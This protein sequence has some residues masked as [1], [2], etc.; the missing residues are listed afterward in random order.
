MPSQERGLDLAAT[1]DAM[2]D[3]VILTDAEGR[4]LR[5]NPVACQLTGWRAANAVGQPLP[6]VFPLVDPRTQEYVSPSADARVRQGWA[7]HQDETALLVNRSGE[8]HLITYRAAPVLDATQAISAIVVTFRDVTEQRRYEQ[9]L[10]ESEQRY[11]TLVEHAPEA[12]V[13]VDVDIGYFVDVSASAVD[14]FGMTRTELLT[15]SPVA[16]SP[17]TQPDGRP[18]AA[19]AEEWLARALAGETPTFEWIHCDA[20]R[21][22]ITCEVRLVRLPSSERRL[23]RGSITDIGE[24]KK[25]ERAL[26][27]SERRNKLILRTTMDGYLLADTAGRILE[28]NPAY[29]AMTGYTEAELVGTNIRMREAQLDSEAV[30]QRIG[31]FL[32]NKQ[33]QFETQHRHRDG[34]AIDLEV[35]INLLEDPEDEPLVIAFVRDISQRKRDGRNIE[36]PS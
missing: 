27:A 24:R 29:C 18:S 9:A 35:S 33:A 20:A 12:I 16:L 19:A 32:A 8:H 36:S 21:R 34:H 2:P 25:A 30:A 4:L 6:D 5:I 1:L 11:R 15:T 22:S 26:R 10:V 13:V 14:L 3:G 28:V 7:A 31:Y 23:V 17:A